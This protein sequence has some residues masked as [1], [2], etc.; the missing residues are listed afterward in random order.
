MLTLFT[1]ILGIV[2]IT[3]IARYNESNKLF[4]ALLTCYMLGFAGVKL[5]HDSFTKDEGKTTFMQVPPTQGLA[6]SQSTF[7][8]LIASDSMP[9][10]KKVTS[11]PVSQ[12]IVPAYERNFT[13]SNVSE[14]A[15]GYIHILPNPPNSVAIIDDS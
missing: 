5:I 8:Y 14:V 1:F 10:P 9:A 15:Q 13:L 11:E 7:V 6:A 4:W 12:A 2:L 3:L